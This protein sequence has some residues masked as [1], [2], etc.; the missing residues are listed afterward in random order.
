VR[1]RDATPD[2][3]PSIAR[4]YNQ[5]IEDRT[6]TLETELRSPDERAAWLASHGPWH[7]VLLAV[8]PC[9]A[10]LGLGFA[11]SLQPTRRV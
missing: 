10:V 9:G 1:I 8:D 2:D 3:A 6:A 4:I 5:G 11:Q 7:P